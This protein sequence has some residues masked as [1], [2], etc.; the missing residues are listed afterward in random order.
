[1]R[2]VSQEEFAAN[3][4]RFIDEVEYGETLIIER[5]GRPILRVEPLHNDDLRLDR[6]ALNRGGFTDP[7]STPAE[8]PAGSVR[9]E[10][11]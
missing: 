2:A 4:D 7:P 8:E 10:S 1:M 9:D 3:V 6:P 11:T 5:D